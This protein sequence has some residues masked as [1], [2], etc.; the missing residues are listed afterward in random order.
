MN[1]DAILIIALVYQYS[2]TEGKKVI[3]KQSTHAHFFNT[4]ETSTTIIWCVFQ[5][6]LSCMRN[7]NSFRQI[8]QDY[9]QNRRRKRRRGGCIDDFLHSCLNIQMCILLSAVRKW[10]THL[11]TALNI[12]EQTKLTGREHP[13]RSIVWE[14]LA[15]LECLPS[16]SQSLKFFGK[17]A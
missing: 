7:C 11:W 8:T 2:W 10:T 13:W 4:R 5:G 12:F 17:K 9:Q 3:E 1:S 16:Y 15:Y 6:R 14:R